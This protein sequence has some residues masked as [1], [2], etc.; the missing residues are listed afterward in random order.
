M[1]V[2]AVD[3][4][5]RKAFFSASKSWLEGLNRGVGFGP[6]LRHGRPHRDSPRTLQVPRCI[7]VTCVRTRPQ[8]VAHH[9][10]HLVR[11]PV[12]FAL[13]SASFQSQNPVEQ[14]SPDYFFWSRTH[15]ETW[16]QNRT[17][18]VWDIDDNQERVISSASSSPYRSYLEPGEGVTDERCVIADWDGYNYGPAHFAAFSFRA[19][20]PALDVTLM[21][22][23]GYVVTATQTYDR[24]WHE[25][26]YSGCLRIPTYQPDEPAVQT[27][28]N[29]NGGWGVP[30]TGFIS[31]TNT[32]A[33]R[34]VYVRGSWGIV[35][36]WIAY[37]YGCTG[38]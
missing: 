8:L 32:D 25:Y 34:N 9:V 14:Q 27:I 28:V 15:P 37:W 16:V 11:Q 21:V 38:G 3:R 17:G 18:C 2:S 12:V 30:T 4:W 1:F 31:I 10:I 29:S 13:N 7:E 35:N 5:M 19:S 20:S 24:S 23:P 26:V 33:R 22:S 6:L 36:G